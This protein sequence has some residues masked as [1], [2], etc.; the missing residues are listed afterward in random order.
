MVKARGGP[1]TEKV[2]NHRRHPASEPPGPGGGGGGGRRPSP[3]L[4]STAA[5]LP[6]PQFSSASHSQ[7]NPQRI[8]DFGNPSDSTLWSYLA[9]QEDQTSVWSGTA[10]NVQPVNFDLLP[11]GSAVGIIS[12][13][14]RVKVT[15]VSLSQDIGWN[16]LSDMFGSLPNGGGTFTAIDDTFPPATSAP[17]P[18][19]FDSGSFDY[20]NTDF[21]PR[22]EMP[23][24]PFS[25]VDSVPS[26]ASDDSWAEL[27]PEPSQPPLPLLDSVSTNHTS[28]KVPPKLTCW[29]VPV[30]N[31]F[32]APGATSQVDSSWPLDLGQ[33]P[34]LMDYLGTSSYVFSSVPCPA[35][36]ST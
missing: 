31:V 9:P 10:D 6:T 30:P 20:L 16:T 4:E 5:S 7:Y 14:G 32:V 26:S 12:P 1:R 35:H 22:W 8:M 11:G 25:E 23:T 33:F 17:F 15:H 3:T 21:H 27:A 29:Q 36:G 13:P 24:P 34:W 2:L 19:S 18:N 28:A